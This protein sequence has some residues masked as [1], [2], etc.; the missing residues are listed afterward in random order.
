MTQDVSEALDRWVSFWEQI[1]LEYFRRLCAMARRRLTG[2]DEAE[3][4]DVV[5]EAFARAITYARNP[6][7]IAYPLAYLWQIV[8][9]VW[10]DKLRRENTATMV[11]LDALDSD[12]H[13]TVPPDA[14]RLLENEELMKTFAVKQGPLT[15]R[16]KKLLELYLAGY[17]CAEIAA[18]LKEK[19]GMTRSD[20]NAVRTKVRYRLMSGKSKTR[21][22]GRP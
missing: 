17:D 22:S 13:P 9:N 11:R 3:A 6:E 12:Q 15:S 16:E 14:L 10:L 4:E 8:R 21:G 2:G 18:I 5:S 7:A 1:Y 19:V 20:L